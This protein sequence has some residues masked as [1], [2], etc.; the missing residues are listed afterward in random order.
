MQV[1]II[2]TNT[3][4][5]ERLEDIIK[6]IDSDVKCLSF[7]FADQAMRVIAN[8]LIQVPNY[9]FIN[10]NLPRLTGPEC[11]RKLKQVPRLKSSKIIMFAEVMPQ[12]VGQAFI[13]RG[14]FDFFQKPLDDSIYSSK[15]KDIFEGVSE[16]P[17]GSYA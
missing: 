11:L 4:D 17:V 8:E 13:K 14:A 15:V 2:D 16:Q 10:V 3:E 5:L 1:A 12:A 7:V 6:Q 9:I